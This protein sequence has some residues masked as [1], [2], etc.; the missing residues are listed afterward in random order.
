MIRLNRRFARVDD[1][2]YELG[3]ECECVV[4]AVWTFYDDQRHDD[5]AGGLVRGAQGGGLV[6]REQEAQRHVYGTSGLGISRGN[7]AV[8]VYHE[9]QYRDE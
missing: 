9:V 3:D 1:G 7:E 2:V 8:H 6:L 5:G 4:S